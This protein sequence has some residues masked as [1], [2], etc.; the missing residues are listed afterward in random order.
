MI[1]RVLQR[2]PTALVVSV[3]AG[4][5]AGNWVSLPVLLP[6]AG[7]A[8]GLVVALAYPAGGRRLIACAM[9]LALLGLAWGSLRA[10]ALDRSALALRIGEAGSARVAVVGPPRATPFSVRVPV[11]VRRF[12]GLFVRERAL[13]E[14]R[15]GRAPPRGAVLEI[16]RARLVA[17]R[18]PETGFDER[19]WLA[20]RGIHVVLRADG[21]RI[22]GRRGGIGGV[23][24]GLRAHLERTLERGVRR[25]AARSAA[26]LR[27]RRRLRART[28]S[29]AGVPCL[30]SGAHDRGI[31]SERRH[32]GRCDRRGGVAARHR[33][34]RDP[35]CRDRRDPRL[36]ARRR[37][38]AVRRPRR[39]RRV[40]RLA[41][42]ARLARRRSLARACAR[43]TR[44]PRLAAGVAARAGV[45]AVVRSCRRDPRRGPS[46]TGASPRAIRSRP[47]WRSAL[48]CPGRAASRRLRSAGHISA[49]S[50]SGASR[51][52]SSRSPPCRP[53]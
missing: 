47:A 2:W 14:I 46:C 53:C 12:A 33:S 31:G 15:R 11:D 7:A 45:S 36:R 49:P 4:L 6:L 19:A 8:G 22:V 35:R 38:G 25:G 43:R 51:R 10:D 13:L 5:A 37:L 21:V 27:A 1:E 32:R 9:S 41:R 20:R 29:P 18:G 48:R 34:C 23:A 28:G 16:V 30:R 42:L 40:R 39:R 26:R 44:P 24:D 17:P 3:C 52:T 50:R